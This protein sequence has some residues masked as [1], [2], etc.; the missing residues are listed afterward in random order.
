MVWTGIYNECSN[1]GKKGFDGGAYRTL[2]QMDRQH[3]TVYR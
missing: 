2:G 3:A 1:D